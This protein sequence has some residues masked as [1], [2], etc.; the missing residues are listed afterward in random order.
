MDAYFCQHGNDEAKITITEENFLGEV[1]RYLMHAYNDELMENYDRCPYIDC[2]NDQYWQSVWL[3]TWFMCTMM[4]RR[5]RVGMISEF[6]DAYVEDRS[7]AL[8][9]LRMKDTFYDIF[10]VRE[11]KGG[12][13]FTAVRENGRKCTIRASQ[14][15]AA[16]HPAGTRFAGMVF[17][18][19]DDG[20]QRLCVSLP[21][22]PKTA[23]RKEYEMMYELSRSFWRPV[24][25][26][27]EQMQ[28]V[29]V[30]P[31]TRLA[32][33]LKKFSGKMINDMCGVLGISKPRRKK[34]KIIE[35]SALLTSPKLC[36]VIGRMQKEQIAVLDIVEG[37]GGI[38]RMG[39]LKRRIGESVDT[40]LLWSQ[41]DSPI[42]LLRKQGLLIAGKQQ[43]GARRYRVAAI[44]SDVLAAMRRFGCIGRQR[45]NA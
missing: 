41:S 35:I 33:V 5:E 9:M 39:S 26:L 28:S 24:R 37:A 18:W 25:M 20:T 40:E 36:D 32:P 3:S 11:N 29:P 34:E 8:R 45:Q 19:Y 2:I 7:L 23:A 38:M 16:V 42:N 12:G 1:H 6:T 10:Y 14:E 17:P 21:L 13:T 30:T 44:P 15:H 31:S 4:G 22:A 27:E 43:A